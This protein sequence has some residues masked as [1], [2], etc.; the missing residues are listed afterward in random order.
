M[1]ETVK[2]LM[3]RDGLTQAEAV[4]Q[5]VGFFKMMETDILEHEGSPSEWE[6]EFVQEFGLEPDYFEDFIFRLAV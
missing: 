1:K 2:V 5:V 6:N 3:S 4:Y